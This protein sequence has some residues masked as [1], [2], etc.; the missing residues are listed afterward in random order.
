MADIPVMRM[1]SIS[2]FQTHTQTQ[3]KEI[4][5]REIRKQHYYI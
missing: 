1:E 4:S 3:Q 5:M 2:A